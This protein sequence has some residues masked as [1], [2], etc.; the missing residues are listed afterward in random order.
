MTDRA[1]DIKLYVRHQAIRPASPRRRATNDEV[2]EYK[3]FVDF[4]SDLSSV[5]IRQCERV[6]IIFPF[7]FSSD[8]PSY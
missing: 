3:S 4:A 7:T 8:G 2:K 1:G 6:Q 5:F